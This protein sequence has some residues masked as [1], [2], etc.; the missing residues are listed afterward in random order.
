[1]NTFTTKDGT[2]I[3]YK[4]WGTGPVVTFSHGWPLVPTPGIPRCSSSVS[5][6]I[7]S[8]R[9]TAAVTDAP[10]KPGRATTWTSTRTISLNFCRSSM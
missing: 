5:K 3:F 9:T 4:D 8:L 2:S 10:A 7:A 6:A 1:M